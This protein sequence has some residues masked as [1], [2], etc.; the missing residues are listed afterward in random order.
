M[1]EKSKPA[2]NEAA[3][4]KVVKALSIPFNVWS[5][6]NAEILLN[7]IEPGTNKIIPGTNINVTGC[8][9]NLESELETSP[10]ENAA[11]NTE[12]SPILNELK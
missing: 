11:K 2:V 1:F 7:P 3:D 8:F 6:T 5:L 12:S 4:N 10:R 9:I